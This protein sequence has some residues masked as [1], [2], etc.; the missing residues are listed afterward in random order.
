M[1]DTHPPGGPAAPQ[2]EPQ[3][4]PRGHEE[5]DADL[6][7]VVGFGVVLAVA[8]GIVLVLL[9]VMF[10]FLQGQQAR[11]KESHFPLAGPER[12]ALPQTEFGSPATGALPP[13]PQLEGLNL[14]GPEHDVGRKRAQGTA[15]GKNDSEEQ[16]LSRAGTDEKGRA[17]LKIEDAMRQVAE[18][19]KPQGGEPGPVRYDRGVPGTGG[20]SNSGRSLPGV[21]R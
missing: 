6:R 2:G 5:R 17:H 3:P 15:A 12:T 14:Q 20:G 21:R 19:Y 11:E 4:A 13:T 7:G 1:T 8:V 18:Q 16:K 9:A 10:H